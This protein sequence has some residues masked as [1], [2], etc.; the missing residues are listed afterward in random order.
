MSVLNSALLGRGLR[1]KCCVHGN[2]C[3]VADLEDDPKDSSLVRFERQKRAHVVALDMHTIFVGPKLVVES[4]ET[5]DMFVGQYSEREVD[6]DAQ[7]DSRMQKVCK[8]RGLQSSH[9]CVDDD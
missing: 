9:G 2:K 5:T 6:H 7:S 1:T 3:K 4:T 8:E